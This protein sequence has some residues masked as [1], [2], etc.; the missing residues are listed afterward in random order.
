L[1]NCT[2]MVAV[3]AWASSAVPF[4]A[5]ERRLIISV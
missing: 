5:L 4:N 1:R 2:R 3:R